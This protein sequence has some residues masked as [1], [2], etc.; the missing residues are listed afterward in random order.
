MQL[1]NEKGRFKASPPIDVREPSQIKEAEA[2]LKRGP[3]TVVLIYADW[4]GHCQ[5]YKPLWNKMIENPDR[6][7]QV[8]SVKEDI[9]PQ[10]GMIKKA[11]IQGYPS[12]IEVS[13][14][15]IIKE[16]KV[17][18]SSESTNAVPYMRDE[19]KMNQVLKEVTDTP[20]PVRRKPSQSP[21]FFKSIRNSLNGARKRLFG[22][23]SY[24]APKRFN[25]HAGTRK[26]R[27]S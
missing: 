4:C 3:K 19:N 23:K 10:I 5:T 7:A 18:G 11:N 25:H 27:R 15:G 2:L 1:R 20:T 21:G 12:V 13:P 22:A 14:S 6:Q 26:A 8:I 16:F 17:S 24:K 9:F